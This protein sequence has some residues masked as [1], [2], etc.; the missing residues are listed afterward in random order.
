LKTSNEA[1]NSVAQHDAVYDASLLQKLHHMML[2]V[3]GISRMGKLQQVMADS[4]C[5]IVPCQRCIVWV[6]NKRDGLLRT[7]IDGKKTEVMAVESLAG[8]AV[9]NRERVMLSSPTTHALYNPGT[10]ALRGATTGYLL[11]Q[12][13]LSADGEVL[14]VLQLM[15]TSMHHF[16]PS[17]LKLVELWAPLAG[18]LFRTITKAAQY[19]E[20]FDSMV[21]LISQINDARD[22]IASGHSRRVTLYALELGRQMNLPPVEMEQLRYAGLLHDLGKLGIPELILFKDKRPS[23]DEYQIIKKH[24]SM[25]RQLLQ[26]IRFPENLGNLAEV[27]SAHHE[28]L[29]G[30]G[31]PLGLTADAIPQ[32]AKIL[33]ICDV[34]DALTSRRPYQDRLA[35]SEVLEIIDKETNHAFEPFLVY[36][37]KQIP[38]N[39]LIQI[40]EFGKNA[41]LDDDDLAFLGDYVVSDLLNKEKIKSDAQARLES[42]FM[43]YYTR[44]YRS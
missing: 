42:T 17:E 18:G 44:K 28:R 27:A 6:Y 10:D 22:Y 16:T 24:A 41:D 31:Y 5:E 32:N 25:T 12:P 14:A 8:I 20:A 23:D 26:R 11:C 33:A 30:K 39:R 34:F 29:D 9:E 37:F 4:L 38:L 1:T 43:R 40:L 15:N 3:N 36:H 7:E 35:I 2:A 21:N 13:A 19:R